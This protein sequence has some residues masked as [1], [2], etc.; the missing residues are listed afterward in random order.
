MGCMNGRCSDGTT[1]VDSDQLINPSPRQQGINSSIN[2]SEY[3]VRHLPPS[4]RPLDGKSPE[5]DYQDGFQRSVG[6]TMRWEL[7]QDHMITSTSSQPE[8]SSSRNGES[9]GFSAPLAWVLGNWDCVV[10]CLLA[11][12]AL[13]SSYSQP[14]KC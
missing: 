1:D 11:N 4:P 8:S 5:D 6:G 13:V 14:S 12:M 9:G 10:T 7:H 3:T 2:S